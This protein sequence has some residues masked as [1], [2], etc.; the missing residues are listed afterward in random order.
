M[1]EGK[2]TRSDFLKLGG[3]AFAGAYL[4]SL[5]GA[6][7]LAQDEAMVAE[8]WREYL[9]SPDTHPLIPNVSYAGYARGEREIPK[10]PV[11]A[12]VRAFGAKGNGEADDTEAIN[13]A[14]QAAAERGGGAVL[15]PPGTYRVTG[16]I[17]MHYSNVV[18][19]G[20]GRYKTTIYCDKSLEEGYR[21]N[22]RG[23]RNQWS[24][25][26]GLVWFVPERRLWTL[27]DAGF[28]GEE[29]W[30]DNQTLA[31]V[32][33]VTSENLRGE[34][35]ITVSDPGG[36]E[37]G[38]TVILASRNI[39]DSSLLEHMCGEVEG[40]QTYDWETDA[41]P[42][43]PEISDWAGAPNFVDLRWPVEI[44]A[45]DG[46]RVTLAQPLKLDLRAEWEPR[47]QSLG[48]A[49]RDAGIEDLTIEM[50]LTE[51]QP[52]LQDKGFNG[53]CF[54]AALDCW[55]RNVHVENSDQ[56]FGM[57]S[58]K[59]VTLENV[60]VGGRQRHHSY[61]CRVQS[62]DNLIRNFA[63]DEATVPLTDGATH[64]GINIEGFSCGNA[65]SEGTMENGTLDS[66]RALPF[67]NVRT[68]ITVNND[69]AVGGAGDAGPLFGARFAHWNVRVTNDRCYAIAIQD[70]APRSVVVGVRGC[71]D[72]ESGLSSDFDGELESET[73]ANGESVT[74]AN[75]YEAQLR[76]RR[77]QRGSAN[78]S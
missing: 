68:D 64:H 27:E 13:R 31:S 20:L 19:R 65:W 51:Q 62:H 75:L 78:T 41:S 56:G 43:R 24:F 55:A 32:T 52:H 22:V 35:T 9:E 50:R 45:V 71:S 21:E 30:M 42:L 63:I 53:P 49:V 28:L 74:P 66:H 33:S 67:E 48:P 34:R 29:G 40:T 18:L 47:L 36:L 39:P 7:A 10:T 23:P 5:P 15:L 77:H 72:Y 37:P 17:R 1:L 76:E 26:G 54:Q 8:L 59:S 73:E 3:G 25:M 14:I 4:A 44:S 58:C 61:F 6:A 16:L 70:V 38:D 69:G 60:S 46:D 11:K 2:I 57:T 12:N